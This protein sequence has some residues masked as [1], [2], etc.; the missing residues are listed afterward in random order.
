MPILRNFTKLK[1]SLSHQYAM[2]YVRRCWCRNNKDQ[3]I[4]LL[5]SLKP[6]SLKSL[7][8][9]SLKRNKDI[10]LYYS[11]IIEFQLLFNFYSFGDKVIKKSNNL[12]LMLKKAVKMLFKA[13]YF[14]HSYLYRIWWQR[15]A[16]EV[17]LA[18]SCTQGTVSRHSVWRSC[19]STSFDSKFRRHTRDTERFFLL[20]LSLRIC[21]TPLP[22]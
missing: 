10:F 13:I 3:H 5:T 12:N 6:H 9:T 21:T 15:S 14:I 11:S 1:I 4:I 20:S 17:K 7:R 8:L 22:L 19:H 2:T 16:F 18:T